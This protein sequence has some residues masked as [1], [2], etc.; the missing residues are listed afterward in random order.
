MAPTVN[1]DLMLR[2]EIAA[3]Y[4]R[5][6]LTTAEIVCSLFERLLGLRHLG[7]ELR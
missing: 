4:H 5:N 7:K 3:L 2:F 6:T 1:F